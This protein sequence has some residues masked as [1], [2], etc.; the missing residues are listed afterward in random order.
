MATSLARDDELPM[1]LPI[2][3]PGHARNKAH[4][5]RVGTELVA[6]CAG[7]VYRPRVITPGRSRGL[8][9]GN[10]HENPCKF[11]RKWVEIRCNREA[12]GAGWDA[13]SGGPGV[14]PLS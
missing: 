8:K 1:L 11:N 4:G 7:L 5:I 2:E 12:K 14:S 3:G 6:V 9:V 13:N 10:F